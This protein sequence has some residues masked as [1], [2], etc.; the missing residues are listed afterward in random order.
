VEGLK[1]IEDEPHRIDVLERGSENSKRNFDVYQTK[2][3][4]RWRRGL[5]KRA[6]NMAGPLR[7]RNSGDQ[8]ED[9]ARE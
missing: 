7:A 1:R 6:S 8:H 3:T 2:L 9:D 4:P 5:G